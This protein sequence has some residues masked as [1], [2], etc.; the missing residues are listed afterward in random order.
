MAVCI[1][2]AEV[3]LKFM[4]MLNYLITDICY[5]IKLFTTRNLVLIT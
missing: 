2:Q 3:T 4:K 5:Q 1:K